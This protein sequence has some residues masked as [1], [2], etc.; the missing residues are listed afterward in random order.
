[1]GVVWIEQDEFITQ[2]ERER[3]KKKKKEKKSKK[4]AYFY[5]Y[6]VF[7]CGHAKI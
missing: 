5:N 1:M 7:L 3:K 4:L 2:G 6:K